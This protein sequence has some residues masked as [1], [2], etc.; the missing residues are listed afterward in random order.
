MS[1]FSRYL[2]ADWSSVLSMLRVSYL[3]Q[4]SSRSFEIFLISLLSSPSSSDFLAIS[5]SRRILFSLKRAILSLE[6][7]SSHLLPS[8]KTTYQTASMSTTSRRAMR[9]FMR[10]G[11]WIFSQVYRKS[12]SIKLF[13]YE[14]MNCPPHLI[15]FFLLQYSIYRYTEY[16]LSL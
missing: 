11:K 15:S 6:L 5:D 2:R 9:I 10:M 14:T 16:Y 4:S 7:L 12:H 1:S 3:P 13:S 8:K